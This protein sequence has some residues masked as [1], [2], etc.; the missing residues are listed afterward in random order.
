MWP[1]S[2]MC[3]AAVVGVEDDDDCQEHHDVDVCLVVLILGP[4]DDLLVDVP[5]PG[6]HHRVPRPVHR[7]QLVVVRKLWRQNEK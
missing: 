4:G 7:V 2:P 6:L 5:V 3:G 1:L